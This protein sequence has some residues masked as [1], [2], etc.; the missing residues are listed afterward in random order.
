MEK[1]SSG[2]KK[3]SHIKRPHSQDEKHRQIRSAT[4][5]TVM[6]AGRSAARRTN[7]DTGTRRSWLG[8]LSGDTE[9]RRRVR[10]V[11]RGRDGAAATRRGG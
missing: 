5:D 2:V 9:A 6:R 8:P 3:R 7:S 4:W 1:N 10:R 11:V